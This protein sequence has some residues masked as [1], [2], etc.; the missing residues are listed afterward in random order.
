MEGMDS[1]LKLA[2]GYLSN[3]LEEDNEY[4]WYDTSS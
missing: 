3:K 2:M 1:S 4:L